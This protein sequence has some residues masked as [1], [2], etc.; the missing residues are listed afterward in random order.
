MKISQFKYCLYLSILITSH[1][2]VAN[3]GDSCS[4]QEMAK[5][6]EL[7][8]QKETNGVFGI[9]D[10]AQAMNRVNAAA[11]SILDKCPSNTPDRQS[12]RKEIQQSVAETNQTISQSC[13]QKEPETFAD[14][15]ND[16]YQNN[17]SSGLIDTLQQSIQMMQTLQAQQQLIKQQKRSTTPSSSMSL[18]KRQTGKDDCSYVYAPANTNPKPIK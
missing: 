11:L 10:S 5:Q 17:T 4:D 3:A 15:G 6:L 18:C 16:N 12:M 1:P 13:S 8:A 7:I 14:Q 9:C 2:W